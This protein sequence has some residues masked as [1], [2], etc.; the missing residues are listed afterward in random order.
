LPSMGSVVRQVHECGFLDAPQY[1]DMHAPQQYRRTD[2]CNWRVPFTEYGEEVAEGTEQQY[3][4]ADISQPGADPITPCG[5]KAHV[6]PE[7]GLGVC[8]DTAVEFGLAK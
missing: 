8:I 6:V 4:I 3:E 1:K 7:P 2:D 5:R